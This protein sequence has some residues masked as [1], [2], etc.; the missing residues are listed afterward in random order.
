M[1]C[2]R[3][4]DLCRGLRFRAGVVKNC[5][6]FTWLCFVIPKEEIAAL[7]LRFLTCVD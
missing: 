5:C 3:S 6:C 1:G 4:V 7:G 2:G